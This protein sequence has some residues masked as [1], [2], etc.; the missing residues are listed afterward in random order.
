MTYTAFQCTG[1]IDDKRGLYNI[2]AGLVND[3]GYN[4]NVMHSVLCFAKG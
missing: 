2:V 1:C 3:D 4:N